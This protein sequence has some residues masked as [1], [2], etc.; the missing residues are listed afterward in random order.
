MW[1]FHTI[2][3]AKIGFFQTRRQKKDTNLTF[4]V[5]LFPHQVIILRLIAFPFAR[6]K[7]GMEEMDEVGQK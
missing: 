3:R 1:L 2:C 6:Q 7:L 4:L 5:G